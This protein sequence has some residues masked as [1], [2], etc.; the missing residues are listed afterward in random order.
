MATH[1]GFCTMSYQTVLYVARK[2]LARCTASL[3]QQ[4]TSQ[5]TNHPEP[6]LTIVKLHAQPVESGCTPPKKRL[7][8]TSSSCHAHY[9]NQDTFAPPSIR[10]THSPPTSLET[11]KKRVPPINAVHDSFPRRT[12]HSVTG[13]SR[14]RSPRRT[15]HIT[16]LT[17]YPLTGNAFVYTIPTR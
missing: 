7:T 3:F 10:S 6:R 8:P 13:I 4:K 16:Y 1:I 15:P 12:H 14:S 2:R 17:V 11:K 9:T 5:P